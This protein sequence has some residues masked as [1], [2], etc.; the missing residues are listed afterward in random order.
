MARRRPSSDKVAPKMSKLPSGRERRKIRNMVQDSRVQY[1]YA[2]YFFGFAIAAAVVNQ[3]LMVRAFRS[4]LIQTLVGTNIDP[5][6]L[7]AAVGAPLQAL[8]LRMTVM[9]PIFGMICAAF[10]IWVTH[11]FVGPQVALKRFIGKLE[12][13]DYSGECRLRGGDELQP[14]AAALNELARALESQQAE[15]K[16]AA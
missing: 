16:R 3:M 15:E 8:A 4:I 6:A 1:R 13:G 11:K 7:Q 14:V 12:S 10:A 9:Y 2:L 5:A